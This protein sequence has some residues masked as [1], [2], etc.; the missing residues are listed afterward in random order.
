MEKKKTIL[1]FYSFFVLCVGR[2][3]IFPVLKRALRPVNRSAAAKDSTAGF[4]RKMHSLSS[5][6]LN[7]VGTSRTRTRILSP[8][9]P[10]TAKP[11]SFTATDACR[12]SK[13][14]LSAASITMAPDAAVLVFC[15]PQSVCPRIWDLPEPLVVR[16]HLGGRHVPRAPLRESVRPTALCGVLLPPNTP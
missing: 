16:R 2:D 8:G 14:A 7:S 5:S 11:A 1:R 13:V 4:C 3:T 12:R 9:K 15:N 10:E 6:P